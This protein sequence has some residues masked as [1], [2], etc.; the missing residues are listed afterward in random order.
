[1]RMK[2]VSHSCQFVRFVPNA[3]D[4]WL[5]PVHPTEAFADPRIEVFQGMAPV[6][7]DLMKNRP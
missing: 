1:M 5:N 6:S 4:S 2:S 3:G 7:H